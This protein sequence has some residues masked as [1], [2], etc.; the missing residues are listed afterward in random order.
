VVDAADYLRSQLGISRSAWIDACHTLGR[1]DA[2]AA[3]AVIA[4]RGDEISSP[5]GYLRG[6]TGRARAGRLNLLGS[7]WGLAERRHDA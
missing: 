7:L 6:M 3:V 2:A 5:G 4:A 1:N